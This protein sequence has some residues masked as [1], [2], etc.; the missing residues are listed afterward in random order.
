MNNDLDLDEND[1]EDDYED[2]YRDDFED[3]DLQ[4][5]SKM[6]NPYGQSNAQSTAKQNVDY[7]GKSNL[8]KL[9]KGA[10][11]GGVKSILS[12]DRVSLSTNAEKYI[13]KYAEKHPFKAMEK[14][15]LEARK[16]LDRLK[17]AEETVH[18]MADEEQK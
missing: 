2:E 17:G 11:Q 3:H 9:P 6:S 13:Q 7:L 12:E 5:S 1:Y 15:V 4:E 16:T 8:G 14:A 18:S 10:K